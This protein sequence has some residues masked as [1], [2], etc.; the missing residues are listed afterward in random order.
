M[1]AP[2]PRREAAVG[3][4]PWWERWFTRFCP[5]CES[6]WTGGHP[7]PETIEWCVVCSDP[8][9]GEMRSWVWRW[10]WLQRVLVV[11]RNWKRGGPP[12]REKGGGR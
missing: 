1:I 7:N 2:V 8:R 6:A 9:T 5:N 12:P 3:E 4:R 10:S 11:N